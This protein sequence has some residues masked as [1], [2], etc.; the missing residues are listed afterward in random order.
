MPNI[1]ELCSN[2]RDFNKLQNIKDDF[3][4]IKE[5]EEEETKKKI[6][7]KYLKHHIFSSYE[8]A[9]DWAI[10]NPDRGIIWHCQL[11]LW[12]EDK[13]KFKSYE[14]EFDRDGIIPYD[15]IRYYTK[16]ELLKGIQE[17]IESYNKKH[18]EKMNEKWWLDEY[19]KLSYVTI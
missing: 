18:P 9:L 11:L 15:V 8:E 13:Q 12:E 19:G 10:K 3:Q 16:E 14:Q 2:Q 17:H 6:I 4:K 5:K 7:E 1:F